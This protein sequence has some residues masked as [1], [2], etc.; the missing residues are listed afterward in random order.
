MSIKNV[1]CQ[2][3]VLLVGIA[4]AGLLFAQ[5]ASAHEDLDIGIESVTLDKHCRMLITVKNYGRDLPES[6]YHAVRPAYLVL[7]KGKQREESK[8]LRTLDKGRALVASGGTLQIISRLTYAQ[9]PKPVDIHIQMEGE[10]LDYGAAN[11]GLKESLDCIPGRGHIA[12]EKIPD[13][14]PDIVV[15][16]ARI[17]PESCE[18]LVSF[19]NLSSV[20]L[21]EGAWD[22]EKGVFLMQ[23]R[24]PSHEREPDISLRQLDPGQT[25]TRQNAH[26]EFRRSLTK[27]SA[28]KW[29]VGLWRVLNE[30]DFPNNQIEIPV[31]ERCRLS[32]FLK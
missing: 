12:G 25:F 14:Q 18:L 23:L 31:P 2:V 30:R 32:L 8:S 6:F 11:N 15:Q 28:E 19:D 20:G 29:R 16:T 3:R 13:T 9:N 27:I 7:E 1:P 26:L 21:D 10:F 22:L 4:L 17:D 5:S 24:L